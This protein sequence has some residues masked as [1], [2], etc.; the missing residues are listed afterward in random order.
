MRIIARKTLRAFGSKH[1]QAKQPLD[2]WYR[3]V[4]RSEW[5]KP[6]GIKQL[7]CSADFLPDNRVIFNIGENDYRLIIKVEYK[8]GTVYIRFIRTHAEVM[9]KSTLNLS[10]YKLFHPRRIK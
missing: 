1:P 6:A 3:L 7:F 10:E 4:N 5:Q 8:L 2:D 9:T